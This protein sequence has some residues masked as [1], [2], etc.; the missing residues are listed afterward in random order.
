MYK[1]NGKKIISYLTIIMLTVICIFIAAISCA[2]SVESS[3]EE[4]LL[5][6]LEDV[7]RQNASLLE[8]LIN[9]KYDLLKSVSARFEL[10]PEKREENLDMFH[11]VVD[12]YHLKR[13]GYC[14][15]D[16]LAHATDGDS[17]YL[18][19]RE[20]FQKGM[21]GENAISDVLRDA[22]DGEHKDVIVMSMPLFDANHVVNGV[23]A[24]TYETYILSDE[25]SVD[26]FDGYGKSFVVT[27]KGQVII[28]ADSDLMQVS[29]N[30]FADILPQNEKNASAM[31]EIMKNI[32]ANQEAKGTMYLGNDS[33]LFEM[34]PVFL[35]DDSVIWYVITVI[36][37]DYMQIRFEPVKSHLSRLVVLISL[38]CL[39]CAV[40]SRF[41]SVKQ[42]KMAY[43]LAYESQLTGGPN[44]ADFMQEMQNKR[45]RL[46]YL[47]VMNIEKFS[48]IKS[49]A[50]KEKSD[51]LLKTV[52][53]II[54]STFRTEEYAGHDKADTFVLYMRDSTKESLKER[55]Q[56]LHDACY[57]AALDMQIPWV[58]PRFGV[59]ELEE[60]E[61]VEA[62]YNKATVAVKDAWEENDCL[63]FYD[64]EDYKKQL[65]EQSIEEEFD[66]A[67]ENKEFEVWYQPKYSVDEVTLKGCEALVR[68]RKT[69]GTLISPSSFISILEKNGKIAT[70][71]E[72]VF[73]QVCEQ[74]R[75]WKTA[76]FKLVPI[77]VNV[78]RASLYR[79]DVLENYCDIM[80]NNSIDASDIQLEITESV[81]SSSSNITNLIGQFRELGVKILMD[82]FGTGY[83]SLSTLNQKCFD[84]IKIDKSLVDMIDDEY[85]RILLGKC[86]DMGRSLGLHIT[87]EGVETKEQVLFLKNTEC[88]DIQGFYFSKALP[89]RAFEEKMS[90]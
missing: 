54:C 68:W 36:P 73:R 37:S 2:V 16:G 64:E 15:V 90:R 63:S 75:E 78:S 82:D 83:S 34:S 89:A 48:L 18:V 47:V 66:K 55:L 49:A 33:Y 88:D 5:Q 70:L 50:G 44:L 62:A 30:V 74:V 3:F 69:D 40:V 60:S 35:M 61:T 58:N 43:S 25:L 7:S 56:W 41:F 26:C 71:D 87:V 24:I 59:F 45:E 9:S 51:E 38:T 86:I 79:K 20:F 67:I 46:G 4:Q 12:T 80:K 31:Q 77:S 14:D 29:D 84:A 27:Q 65:F 72:Y 11:T 23:S 76:K 19:H 8:G 81:V 13:I 32:N 42:R 53:S 85:G 22:M 39:L 21:A 10:E 6:N 28:S 1:K 17:T 57:K 52:W